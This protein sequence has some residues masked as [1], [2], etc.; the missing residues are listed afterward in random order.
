MWK[1]IIFK[2]LHILL[3]VFFNCAQPAKP[4]CEPNLAHGPSASNLWFV[5]QRGVK[6]IL[7]VGEWES[8]VANLSLKRKPNKTTMGRSPAL[9]KR[10][11]YTLLMQ[12]A[13]SMPEEPSYSSLSRPG[14]RHMSEWAQMIKA[15]RPT[16]LMLSE[17][18][19]MIPIKPCP[20]CRSVGKINM[21]V[22]LRN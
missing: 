13:A 22:A 7:A 15:F 10:P 18:R 17:Q 3:A 11:S 12:E 21:A 19:W 9:G 6:G 16:Q 2:H 1:L 14:F 4:S 8:L 5:Y 20:N